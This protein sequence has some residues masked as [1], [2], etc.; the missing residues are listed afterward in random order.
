MCDKEKDFIG[1]GHL[2]EK[3]RIMKP[4]RTTRPRG[5]QCWVLPSEPPGKPSAELRSNFV[6]FCS[7]SVNL[8]RNLLGI[9]LALELFPGAYQS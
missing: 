3:S 6:Y 7:A 1:K 9:R 8:A 5:S 2:V 4:R